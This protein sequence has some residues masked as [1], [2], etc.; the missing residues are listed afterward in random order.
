MNWVSWYVPTISTPGWQRQE[1]CWELNSI[2]RP[3]L[4]KVNKF[5]LNV[6]ITCW[7]GGAGRAYAIK[8]IDIKLVNDWCGWGYLLV[9]GC[10]LPTPLYESML[11]FLWLTTKTNKII[12]FHSQVTIGYLIKIPISGFSFVHNNKRQ[13]TMRAEQK[14]DHG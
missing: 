14:G 9:F 4:K 5:F 6:F 7:W 1:D 11:N 8:K 13:S 3:C 10:D 12:T 2:V